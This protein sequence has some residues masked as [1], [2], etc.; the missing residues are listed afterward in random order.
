MPCKPV[1]TEHIIYKWH[2]NNKKKIRSNAKKCKREL[3]TGCVHWLLQ[4]NKGQDLLDYLNK[5]NYKGS[6]VFEEDQL[7]KTVIVLPTMDQHQ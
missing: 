4:P 2:N 7:N 1:W 3:R 5:N 6:H